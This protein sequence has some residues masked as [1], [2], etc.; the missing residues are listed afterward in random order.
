VSQLTPAQQPYY[1]YIYINLLFLLFFIA[2]GT[3]TLS[4]THVKPPKQAVLSPSTTL[5]IRY[6]KLPSAAGTCQYCRLRIVNLTEDNS[7]PTWH[8]LELLV[9]FLLLLG[10]YGSHLCW[11][12]VQGAMGA[13]FRTFQKGNK[14]VSVPYL[15]LA[16]T[17]LRQHFFKEKKKIPKS[18]KSKV[19]TEFEFE[20][21]LKQ[22]SFIKTEMTQPRYLKENG[23]KIVWQE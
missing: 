13:D 14:K 20:N 6:E 18:W 3:T 2:V 17:L 9:L 11:S 8:C 15:I 23:G 5:S 1:I 4:C 22:L 12:L 7:F 19:T 16:F 10:S 21:W